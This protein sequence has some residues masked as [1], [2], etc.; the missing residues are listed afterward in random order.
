MPSPPPAYH[1]RNKT[2]VWMKASRS[3]N[4]TY[5]SGRVPQLIR[6]RDRGP[7]AELFFFVPRGIDRDPHE[8]GVALFAADLRLLVDLRGRS[9]DAVCPDRWPR[10]NR[11]RARGHRPGPRLHAR[12][13]WPSRSSGMW[14]S[15][16]PGARLVGHAHEHLPLLHRPQQEPIPHLP[17]GDHAVDELDF[18]ILLLL[19]IQLELLGEAFDLP[20]KFARPGRPSASARRP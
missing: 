20:L 18:E 3:W 12:F 8:H 6:C 5:P 2:C 4:H 1:S 13:T 9:R 16:S 19:R 14:I 17:R 7:R 15:S 11:P 10:C